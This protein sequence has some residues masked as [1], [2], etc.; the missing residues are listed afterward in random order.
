VTGEPLTRW[1]RYKW[2][3]RHNL[4]TKEVNAHNA[5]MIEEANLRRMQNNG[6]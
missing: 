3:E 2:R 1:A 6:R 4:Y 5:R